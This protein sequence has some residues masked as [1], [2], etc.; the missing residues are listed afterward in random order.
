MQTDVI[1]VRGECIWALTN[2]L[3][4]AGPE[5][6]QEIVGLGYFNA[7][8]EALE[9]VVDP[10]LV[11]VALEGIKYALEAGK[12]LPQLNDENPFVLEIERTGLLDKLEYLQTSNC[13]QVFDN[14]S[15]ILRTYFQADEVF[16]TA[17]MEEE[18]EYEQQTFEL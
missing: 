13:D 7:T 11:F 16:I 14:V 5:L 1:S 9:H 3:T 2:A 12:Q 15:L 10:K 8:C 18:Q 6:I 17:P 4:K